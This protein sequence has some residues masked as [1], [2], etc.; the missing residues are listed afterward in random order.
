MAIYIRFGRMGQPATREPGHFAIERASPEIQCSSIDQAILLASE[1]ARAHMPHSGAGSVLF[2]T[3]I[4]Q[5]SCPRLEWTSSNRD[6][7]VE[8]VKK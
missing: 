7:F 5:K 1:I 2:W 3:D 8:L 4:R 6:F